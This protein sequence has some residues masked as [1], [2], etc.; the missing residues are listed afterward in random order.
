MMNVA[1]IGLGN[2]SV[3]ITNYRGMSPEEL[4]DAA[5]KEILDVRGN[6]PEIIRQQLVAFQDRLRDV[7]VRYFRKAQAEERNNIY[8]A[9]VKHGAADIAQIIRNM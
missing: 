6:P 9:L 2:V 8:G 3:T 4:A 7:L 1:G 5:M